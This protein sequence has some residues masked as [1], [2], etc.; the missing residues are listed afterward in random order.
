[1]PIKLGPMPSIQVNARRQLVSPPEAVARTATPGRDQAAPGRPGQP[2]RAAKPPASQD[3]DRLEGQR[4]GAA[5]DVSVHDDPRFVTDSEPD[6]SGS[7]ITGSDLI[8][9]ELGGKVIEEI[10]EG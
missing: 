2:G 5:A 1:M 7:D 9:R 3:G 10:S 4:S 6:G 8:L